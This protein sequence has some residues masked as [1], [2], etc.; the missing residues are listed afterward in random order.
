MLRTHLQ[1]R[2]EG[3][4]DWLRY[5]IIERVFHWAHKKNI[6]KDRVVEQEKEI[7]TM[8]DDTFHKSKLS[9]SCQK[10]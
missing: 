1:L 6:Q 2:S 7:I 10:Y 5:E 8:F 4:N 3:I 9:K